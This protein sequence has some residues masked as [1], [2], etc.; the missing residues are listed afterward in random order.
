MCSLTG[1]VKNSKRAK[2]YKL[3]IPFQW[4]VSIQLE[5]RELFFSAKAIFY[6]NNMTAA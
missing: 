5:R 2:R 4:R 1:M 6:L 3:Q